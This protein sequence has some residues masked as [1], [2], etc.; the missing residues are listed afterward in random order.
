M[1]NEVGST[2]RGG[3]AVG[4]RWVGQ[5]EAVG[6]GGIADLA[7]NMKA[8]E[9][10]PDQLIAEL[11]RLGVRHL[12]TTTPSPTYVP[13]TPLHLLTSLANC[14]DARVRSALVPLF[15][16]R[17]D[18]AASVRNA[19]AATTGQ[20][21]AMLMC[22]YSAAVAM[23][24]GLAGALGQLRSANALPLHD[25]FNQDLGVTANAG[26][27]DRLQEVARRHA[28]L[29]GRDINWKGTYEHAVASALRAAEPAV[30]WSP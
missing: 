25:F 5:G 2:D 21:R 9:P 11:H 29:S 10:T 26:P 3:G 14:P 8:T 30:E 16:W 12:A 7:G 4:D 13:L 18:F 23:E 27:V 28:Q 6:G 17:P 1:S 20:A 15:L 22:S 24:H 19:A